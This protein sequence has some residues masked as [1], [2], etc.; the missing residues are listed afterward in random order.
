MH[1]YDSSNKYIY[2]AMRFIVQFRYLHCDNELIVLCNDGAEHYFM[3]YGKFIFIRIHTSGAHC[4]CM[5]RQ[6]I[7]TR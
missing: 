7:P 6:V 4:T 5:D 2:M 1:N 3:V